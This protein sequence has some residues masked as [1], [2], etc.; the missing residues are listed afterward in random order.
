[1]KLQHYRQVRQNSQAVGHSVFTFGG[2]IA[3]KKFTQCHI[4]KIRIFKN[5]EVEFMRSA[6]HIPGKWRIV[7]WLQTEWV[8]K[9]LEVKRSNFKVKRSQLLNAILTFQRGLHII[10]T[11]GAEHHLVTLLLL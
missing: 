5:S 4:Q 11:I 2:N 3:H 1:M 9:A 10:S 8:E 7:D 6:F